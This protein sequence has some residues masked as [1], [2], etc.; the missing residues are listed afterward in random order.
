MGGQKAFTAKISIA[1]LKSILS[2]LTP[3]NPLRWN[4][5]CD[6]MTVNIAGYWIMELHASLRWRIPRVYRFL[7]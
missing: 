6:E 1:V 4:T 7:H 3:G 2:P 5:A